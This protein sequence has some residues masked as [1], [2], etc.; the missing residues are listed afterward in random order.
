MT[1][2]T[3]NAREWVDLLERAVPFL[4]DEG[5]KYDDDGSNEPLELAREIETLL[6]S[7]SSDE[8][9]LSP[10]S[11]AFDGG[12]EATPCP[13]TRD[14][15]CDCAAPPPPADTEPKTLPVPT[16]VYLTDKAAV[17]VGD[18]QRGWDEEGPEAHNCD[19][20]GC[21]TIGPHVLARVPFT[22]ERALSQPAEGEDIMVDT[23]YDV[24]ILPL[25]P[26]G[27]DGNGPRFVVHVPAPEQ[28]PAAEA[29]FMADSVH[30]QAMPGTREGDMVVLETDAAGKPTIWCDPEIVDLVRALND[31]GLRTV[32]SCSGHG[33]PFG[34]VTL[35]D[36]RE[37]LVLPDYE[38]TRKAERILGAALAAEAQGGGEVVWRVPVL[39]SP[40]GERLDHGV[41]D[42]LVLVMHRGAHGW[43]A[44]G[45][46]H[47]LLAHQLYVKNVEPLCAAS[48]EVA[49]VG[50]YGGGWRTVWARS[51]DDV[52]H[53]APP[54]APVG[55]SSEDRIVLMRLKDALPDVGLNGWIYGVRVI[56]RILA[57]QPAVDRARFRKA[58]CYLCGYNGP[59]YF[60][61]E[62]HPCAALYHA[63]QHQEP[64]TPP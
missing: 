49:V 9:A 25:R 41:R 17:I 47:A 62:T 64:A 23:P 8:S 7:L 60:Q 3:S 5:A 48:H 52:T 61:P 18:P 39:Q 37:L 33:G 12:R 19:D 4:L 38:T 31:G 22:D 29:L 30:N 46:G 13:H 1:A 56:E 43:K 6:A 42:E 34:I 51:D 45:Q 15:N 55:I 16:H 59:G 50:L 35:K 36:G 40:F 54:S 11:L 26:S 58:P 21:S 27:L 53:P 10:A 2:E 14:T 44:A 32:A 20:M 57:Q 28:Q 63:A 24:F